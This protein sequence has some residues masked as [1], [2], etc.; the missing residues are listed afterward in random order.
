MTRFLHPSLAA[1]S[2]YVPGEQPKTAGLIKLNTN[3]APFDPPPAVMEAVRSAGARLRLYPDPESTALREALGK[4]LGVPPDCLLMTNGS[5]ELLY[6]AFMAYARN[7]V[8]FP[9][10]TYG[11]YRVLADLLDCPTRILPLKQDMTVDADAFCRTPDMAVI[12]NPNAPTGL[13]LPLAEV[14]RIVR[15]DPDRLVLIDEAYVDFG[16]ESAVGLTDKYD[17]LIV[18]R[19]FSK[20]RAL[21]GGRLGFGVANKAIIRELTAIKN[22]INPYNVN[23]LTQ[24]AGLACL[25]EDAYFTAACKALAALRDQTADALRRLGCAVLPSKANFL[26][27]RAPGVP[28][29]TLFQ[30]LREQNILTRYFDGPRTKDCIR[31]TIGTQEQMEI[32][33]QAVRGIMEGSK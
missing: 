9:D 33:T 7:G 2:P 27:V 20:S 14:E 24:A 10:V 26:F 22:A 15:E 32:F 8:A 29:E 18:A 25:R 6:Y 16:G 21:A 13:F 30:K 11:F 17:N 1:L 19:T 5:D 31:V 28:G 12:T 4:K 3:E 23:A